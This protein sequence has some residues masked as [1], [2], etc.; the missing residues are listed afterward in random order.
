MADTASD[1]AKK[2]VAGEQLQDVF[3]LTETQVKGL[4]ALGRNLYEQGKYSDAETIF[5]GLVATNDKLYVGYAGLGA[6]YLAG[7]PPDLTKAYEN[8]SKAAELN[9]NETSIQTNLGEVLLRQAKFEESAAHFK[10]AIELDPQQKDPAANRARAIVNGLNTVIAEVK[11]L[12]KG[13]AA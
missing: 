10:R 4:A 2:I 6:V 12:Q 9:P 8:L 3:G 11:R 1:L 13:A 5:R 7:N